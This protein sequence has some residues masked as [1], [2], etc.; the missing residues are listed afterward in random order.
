ME[1]P[2]QRFKVIN[3]G[4]KPDPVSQ[5]VLCRVCEHHHGVS[6]GE[7]IQVHTTVYREGNEL[8]PAGT[9]ELCLNCLLNGRKTY[10]T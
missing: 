4:N 9:G 5:R 8:V 6:T 1:K 7:F 10:M 3:G 2:I